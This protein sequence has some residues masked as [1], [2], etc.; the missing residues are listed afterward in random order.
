M[1]GHS[2]MPRWKLDKARRLRARPLACEA[3][4]YKVLRPTGRWRFQVPMYGYIV[5]FYL[6]A[7]NL[8]VELDGPIHDQGRDQKR[9]NDLARYKLTVLR[10]PAAMQAAAILDVVMAWLAQHPIGTCLGCG[11]LT[12]RPKWCFNCSQN[13]VREYFARWRRA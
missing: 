12:S 11:V 13:N 10:F 8:I 2:R 7:R 3:E 4:L 9:D 1:P 5:D 6:P